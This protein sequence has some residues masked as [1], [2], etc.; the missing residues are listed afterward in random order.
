MCSMLRRFLG[1]VVA[2][3]ALLHANAI[4]QE[5][6]PL[7]PHLNPAGRTQLSDQSQ[8][9][10]PWQETERPVTNPNVS[11]PVE[12][13]QATGRI[14]LLDFRGMPL[15]DAMRSFSDATG[16]NVVVSTDA[17]D[18]KVSVYLRQVEP[19]EAL[20]SIAKA[21]GLYYTVDQASGIVRISTTG[22]YEKNLA[23]FRE[24]QTQV[25]TL[26]YPNPASI[27]LAIRN[28]F[29]ERVELNFADSDNGDLVDLV[30]RFSR[31]DLVDGRS[32]GLGNFQGTGGQNGFN[33]GLGGG[34]NFGAG[35]G[36]LGGRGNNFGGAGGGLGLLGLGGGNQFGNQTF[37][38][39]FGNQTN[40][41]RNP[42]DDFER[43][44][45]EGLTTDQILALE[46]AAREGADG[47]GIL[48]RFL[49]E[50]QATIYVTA[51]RRNNQLIVRTGD[52][53]TMQQIA[54]LVAQ[55]DVPTP[56]VL[57]EVKVLRVELEDG[58]NS[59]FDYQYTD[60]N[61]NA[62]TFTLGS[63][64]PIPPQ[65]AANIALAASAFSGATA[66]DFTFQFVDA[67]FRAKMQLL[68]NLNRVTVLSTPL[69][70]TANNEVS[71]IF[72]GETIPFTTGFQ[73]A[74]V[75]PAN[76]NAVAVA[77]TPIT[78]DRDV[79][80]SLLITPNI[81]ADRT[82]TLRIVQENS[83]RV[84]NGATIP[85]AS[86]DG[87][88]VTDQPVD[89]ITR[90]TVSGTVVAKDGL[91]VALGGLIEENINDLEERVPLLGKIPGLGFFFKRQDQGSRR[92]ELILMIRPYVFNT[93]SES[94]AL[95][96]D[97]LQTLS[98]HPKACDPS[99]TLNTYT[100][101]D[102]IQVHSVF[103]DSCHNFRFHN[104]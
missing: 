22:E 8:I 99:G 35:G 50:R 32:L 68:E 95:S 79:G 46:R 97:L 30:Q 76:N 73:S 62:G 16:I 19:M 102:A 98:V 48:S 92:T 49:E 96:Q 78:E 59:V 82:V 12:W 44:R 89:T 57:L 56:L 37:G 52:E 6:I 23:S 55:L 74:Q 58:F 64:L 80:Q 40:Q 87:T 24:E 88:V 83:R 28:V 72:V 66:G 43:R 51:I 31:F 61:T 11:R 5:Q 47:Q 84:E 3:F 15:S 81:N 34:R 27:A 85:L 94:A 1:F 20:D 77:A 25:F 26:L 100:P 75:I 4:A 14:P 36:F 93:P 53:R 17:G 42:A 13:D 60:G 45:L 54:Q 65:N 67:G 38:N 9:Q 86:A 39:Q 103:R 70:L 21:N 2:G 90:S 41:N 63:I 10:N 7:P 69:L 104:Q 101:D 29:G 18:K 33:N 71:R 91:S